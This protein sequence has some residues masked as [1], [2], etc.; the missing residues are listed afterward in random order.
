MAIKVVDYVPQPRKANPY[1][2]DIA[3]LVKLTDEKPGIAAEIVV[4]AE[5]FS[6][7]TDKFSKPKYLMSQA[8]IDLNRTCSFVSIVEAKDGKTAT[9]TIRIKPKHKSGPRNTGNGAPAAE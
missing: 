6:K 1:A 2:D 7:G 4:S 5:G 8:A 3:E 9:F